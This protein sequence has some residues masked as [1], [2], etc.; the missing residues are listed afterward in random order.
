[1][2]PALLLLI[3]LVLFPPRPSFAEAEN[4]L[5]SWYTYWGLG[6]VNNT[7][8]QDREGVETLF[9]G[10][11]H[12]SGTLD[13]FGFYLPINEYTAAGAI[14]SVQPSLALTLT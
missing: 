10:S 5:E 14:M 7:Y 3:I 11:N 13:L 4:K 9:K 6:Y 2:R 12:H 1:M 8:P